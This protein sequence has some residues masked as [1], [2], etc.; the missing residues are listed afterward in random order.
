[1]SYLNLDEK[2]INI[3][4]DGSSL[5]KPRRGGMGARIVWVNESGEEEVYDYQPFGVINAT[6]QEMEIKA[7]IYSLM[8][9]FNKNAPVNLK[10]FSKIVI[11]SDSLYLVQNFNL[12]KFVW[13]KNG[14]RLS[15]GAPVINAESWKEL[16]RILRKNRTPVEIKWVKAHKDSVHNKAADK[17]AKISAKQA[18]HKG[19]NVKVR[20]KKSPFVV[21][22]GSIKLSGQKAKIRI[23]TDEYL[24]TQ[25]CYRYKYEMMSKK[26]KYYQRVDWVF[27]DI[28]LSAGHT[29]NVLFNDDNKYPQILEKYKEFERVK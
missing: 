7:C 11:Y 3:F 10:K 20:R 15:G 14:W 22:P 2:A 26:S 27:S 6:N 21:D 4:T 13:S 29:Y 17:L 25:R 16:V 8:H 18:I 28:M 19:R 9:V 24:R 12:A 1:M 5:Q 23:I